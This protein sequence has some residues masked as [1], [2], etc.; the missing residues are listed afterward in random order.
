MS[1]LANFP[2]KCQLDDLQEIDRFYTCVPTSLAAC[3]QYLTGQSFDGAAIKDEVYAVGYQGPTDPARYVVYCQ[4]HGVR[5]YAV[6]GSNEQLITII[7]QYLALGHPL[8]LSEQDP[9]VSA[10]LGFTHVVASYGYDAES[11]TVMD[12]F[13]G[14]SIT[15]SNV[16]WEQDLRYNQVWV[17]EKIEENVMLSIQQA[18]GFFTEVQPD[19]VWHC[20]QTS[21]NV[22]HGILQYYRTCTNNNLNG[23]SILGL[24]LSDEQP[25]PNYSGCTI[26]RYERSCVIYDPQYKIDRVPGIS[27]PC[28]P[29]HIDKE[30][31]R[32]PAVAQLTS[33]N[34]QLLA[35]IAQLEQQL[36]Q[37]KIPP[38]ISTDKQ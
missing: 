13:I 4:Q 27:G 29:A 17:L 7:Q 15:K 8:L 23:L 36:A 3:L 34:S 35:K 5:M 31:G 12:P 20:K 32:D 25:I 26:Q 28:Y 38:I 1:T 21:Y 19:Q 33:E 22:S 16:Q 37:A 30:P 11:I 18:S 10:S 24:P 14:K 6:N 2:V 9:Y